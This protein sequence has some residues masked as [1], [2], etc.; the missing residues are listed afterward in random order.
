MKL[1]R[2]GALYSVLTTNLERD[3]K[4]MLD[5]KFILENTDSVRENTKLRNM[6][7]D[8]SRLVELAG[9]RSSLI[10]EVEAKRQR[11]N[12]IAKL[13]RGKLSKEERQ[14]LIDEG[15]LLK[16]DS[17]DLEQSIRDVEAEL[18]DLQ[19]SIPNMTHPDAPKGSTDEDNKEIKKWGELPSFD[20]TPKDHVDL[21][22]ALDL[23]DWQGGTKVSGAKFYFLKRDAVWLELALLRYTL[24]IL[25]EHGFVIHTTPDLAKQDIIAGIGFNPRGSETQIYSIENS[26]LALIATAEI[27]LGGMLQDEILE[28]D[29]LPLKVGGISHCFR[30]EAG[31]AGRASRGLYRVHQFTKVEMFAFTSSEESDA[32]LDTFLAVEEKIFQ[33][34]GI[35][36]RVVDCCTGDL[37]AQAYR[38]YD[39]EAW[40]PG[41][42]DEG[43]Y[44]EVTSASNCTD[45]QAR[46]L[47]IR[48]R[49]EGE[50]R[51]RIA[52]T[53]NG[54]AIAISRAL[55][56]VM[57][58]YQQADGS[59]L[60]PEALRTWVGKDR[61]VAPK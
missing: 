49:H 20:F 25:E 22:E 36:Y 7:A 15:K 51:P 43:K 52:H 1:R 31:A 54:T 26:D 59:I 40:M 2:R 16:T 8:F 61:I 45:Y 9:K 18:H 42:G 10:Q 48:Y 12:E 38:K 24:S 32:M 4:V 47:K 23:I 46:R 53:L 41:R 13:M 14:P 19:V 33:G 21:A 29:Q 5:L 34:L 44:G 55:I 39:I 35:P 58:N 11:A 17:S 6:D 27:T 28:S 50:K 37:G 60:V 56:A 30:T 57:E 3:G